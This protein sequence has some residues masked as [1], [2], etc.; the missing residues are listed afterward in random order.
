MDALCFMFLKC[1]IMDAF[2]NYG[3]FLGVSF[4]SGAI[5]FYFLCNIYTLV[6]SF[7]IVAAEHGSGA[8]RVRALFGIL[9]YIRHNQNMCVL[10]PSFPAQRNLLC[11]DRMNVIRWQDRAIFTTTP[12]IDSSR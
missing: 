4:C 11:T 8:E 1:S 10:K 5:C 12:F 2:Q 7:S 9:V 6:R 3:Y